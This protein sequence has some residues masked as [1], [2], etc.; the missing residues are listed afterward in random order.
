MK[1]TLKL[2]LLAV[3]SGAYVQAQA[4]VKPYLR[5]ETGRHTAKVDRISV[6]ASERF[7]VSASDDKTARVWDL[8][9]G[10]LLE[11]L[12]PPIGDFEEGKAYAV[13]ISPDGTTVAVGGFMGADRSGNYPIY[14]FDRESGVIHNGI[15]GIPYN[16]NHLAYSK[17]GRYLAAALGGG[18]GLRVFET[19]GYSE[20]AKDTEYGGDSYD[21]EFDS[22][23]RLVTTSYDGFIRLY[24][25]QFRLLRK[26]KAHSGVEPF[27]ARF[28][29]DG[30]LL[31]VGF[32]DA[33]AI[34]ILSADDLSFQY[35]LHAPSAELGLSS[36]AWSTAT[37]CGAGSYGP[38]ENSPVICWA[39]RKQRVPTVFPIA[40]D[41]LMDLLSLKEGALAFCTGDGSVGVLERSGAFRWRTSAGSL[42]FRTSVSGFSSFLAVSSDG[43]IVETGASYFEPSQWTHHNIRF[44][45]AERKLETDPKTKSL[46]MRPVFDGLPIDNWED[47]YNPTLN[48]KALVL[49]QGEMSRSLAISPEKNSFVLGSDWY[50]RRFDRQG[51]QIWETSTSDVAWRVNISGDGRFV[52]AALGDGTL[53]WY[54]FDTGQ[55]ILALF[56]DRDLKRWVAW[57]PDGFFT[58]EGGGD[59]LI[60]Y[61]I[62]RGPGREGDFVKVDQLREV[63]YQP[64]LISQ[65]LTPG[66]EQALAVAR[67]RIGDVAGILAGGQPPEIELLSPAQ[68][69]VTEAYLLQFRV[70]DKG[71]GHGK[72]VYRLDG[73]EIEGLEGRGGVDIRGSGGDTVSRTIPIGSGA[74]TLTVTAYSA[75]GKIE[76]PPK[77]IQIRRLQAAA[78]PS[79][80]VIAAGISYYSDNSLSGGVKFAAAD[81]DLVAARFKEQEGRGLYRQVNAIA[82]RDREATIANITAQVAR[83]A[84]VV[85]PGDTFVLYL[86]GHGVAE[87]GEYYFVP[88]EAEYTNREDWLKKSLN[89]EAI[90]ALLKQISTNKSLVILDTCNA[91]SFLDGREG[92]AEK[93]ALERVALMSGR[94][95]LAAS[96]SKE[97]A[98][99]GYQDHGVFTYV[100]LQGLQEAESNANGEILIHRL[101]EFVL[102]HVPEVTEKKWNYR[103]LPLWKMEGELFPIARKSAKTAN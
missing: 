8:R 102:S 1:T 101:A 98:L 18:G 15:S 42:D 28:S 62:N 34:D 99:E 69:D 23:G 65:I 53:R 87:Q 22:S 78:V 6:D 25:P 11:I 41:I 58:S 32:N 3:L 94:A 93:A 14:V 82:L 75:N 81:A 36:T 38:T 66:G 73:A 49:N 9:R 2:V 19:R 46:L 74:H 56:V 67:R 54:T 89:R 63:F 88:W 35:S 103:Q 21:V 4:P 12:R 30:K 86:A 33:A 17:D 79:L 13:A 60:G 20:V 43:Q 10:T 72:F 24:T 64:D 85:K 97:M 76:S 47:T 27:S 68:A 77:T 90:Q 95:V 39:D 71:R 55:E 37:I 16:T 44:S 57:T 40:G 26:V 52:V 83:V 48:G 84:K 96:N 100:L 80:Y 7:L 59:A 70:N 92:P 31:A 51:K 91:G 45:V 50:I 29:P 61:H 5:I